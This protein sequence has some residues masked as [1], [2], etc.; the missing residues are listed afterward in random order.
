MKEEKKR[1]DVKEEATEKVK[2]Q[3]CVSAFPFFSCESA[4]SIG[5]YVYLSISIDRWIYIYIPSCSTDVVVVVSKKK[6][7]KGRDS[8]LCVRVY[9]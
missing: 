7:K 4:C 9:V 2:K 6:K 1:K 5:V 3:R 8:L